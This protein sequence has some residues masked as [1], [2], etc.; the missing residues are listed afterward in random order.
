M[1]LQLISSFW[2][3]KDRTVMNL[4]ILQQIL[5][6]GDGGLIF[7]F[8]RL[9][10]QAAAASPQ[11]RKARTPA[12]KN[13]NVKNKQPVRMNN[14]TNA[15]MPNASLE[16]QHYEEQK[17][18]IVKQN[19]QQQ[20]QNQMSQRQQQINRP[21]PVQESHNQYLIQP[22]PRDSKPQ[23][24]RPLP[25]FLHSS[26]IQNIIGESGVE[27]VKGLFSCLILVCLDSTPK[28]EEFSDSIRMLVLL[29]NGEQRLITFTLPKE[30]CTIQEI[31]EQVGVPFT[32][33]TPIQVSEANA[34][35][36][37]YIVAVGNFPGFCLDVQ[38][39]EENNPTHENEFAQQQQ[40]PVEQ[41]HQ[42]VAEPP[43]TTPAPPSPDPPKE[44][45]P[46]IIEG[47][48]AVCAICGYLS[49]DFNRC[50]RCKRKLPENVKAIPAVNSNGK[51]M[52]PRGVGDKRLGLQ[53]TNGVP[54][55]NLLPK[56]RPI[57]PKL[58]E[59]ETVVVSSDEEESDKKTPVKNVSEQLLEKLGASVTISPISKEPSIVDIQKT[60]IAHSLKGIEK[61]PLEQVNS[62]LVLCRTVRIGSYR[63]V[64]PEP[65]RIDSNG[66]FLKVPHPK[67]ENSVKGI[68][69]E[70][71][72]IV[73][74]L[75]S[76]Q[77][78][79]PVLFYYLLPS[80]GNSVRHILDMTPGSDCY[81]DPLSEA[82]EAHRRI[83]LL[84]E[85]LS[86]DCKHTLQKI[87]QKVG[88]LDELTY[89]EANDILIKTCPKELSKSV[90]NYRFVCNVDQ[91][92]VMS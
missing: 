89:K 17:S 33:E 10:T 85:T 61:V 44:L 12:S 46:K 57:K 66:V 40:L 75:I 79:L 62:T 5:Y 76:F 8:Y 90:L 55:M 92:N 30:A 48:L 25:Q 6:C 78:S 63:F 29:D 70:N 52:D 83:T 50:M 60:S 87:Y 32:K 45:P 43:K 11:Q 71:S 84:P 35:G 34:N 4:N 80:V 27:R 51:K 77:K 42:P 36:L 68:R 3:S 41:E 67:L 54:R 24:Q 53:K 13:R 19:M 56:K 64:P 72:E 14:R 9:P 1:P 69:I 65:I 28:S 23:I 20:F 59:C 2:K 26:Q 49:E 31:L 15:F 38:Q 22:R 81:F 86:E 47:Q 73:K 74:V 39:T 16:E 58:L 21:P 88:M 82:E 91:C 37:N 18:N 7:N